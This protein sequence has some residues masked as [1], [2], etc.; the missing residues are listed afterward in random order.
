MVFGETLLF[1]ALSHSLHLPHAHFFFSFLD[2]LILQCS[3]Q[4]NFTSR[5][6]QINPIC[7]LIFLKNHI[8]SMR[9]LAFFGTVYRVLPILESSRV[10]ACYMFFKEILFMA[11]KPVKQVPLCCQNGGKKLVKYLLL[12]ASLSR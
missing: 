2:Y 9:D 7:F 8:F 10:V 1:S 5:L 12:T 4:H 11:V 3:M 6:Q